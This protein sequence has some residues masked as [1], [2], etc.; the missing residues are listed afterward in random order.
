MLDSCLEIHDS[1]LQDVDQV[2]LV[3]TLEVWVTLQLGKVPR[4]HVI[5]ALCQQLVQAI[6]LS[7]NQ[8]LHAARFCQQEL[9]TLFLHLDYLVLFSQW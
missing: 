3:D 6:C 8:Q 7:R 2:R 9:F 1:Q 4:S 5:D